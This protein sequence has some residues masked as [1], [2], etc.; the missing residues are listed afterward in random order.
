MNFK[1]PDCPGLL[2]F[3]TVH[4]AILADRNALGFMPFRQRVKPQ[5]SLL[6]LFTQAVLNA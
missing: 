1:A 5:H 6:G 4:A 2:S 3:V